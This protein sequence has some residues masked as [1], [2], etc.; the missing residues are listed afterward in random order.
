MTEGH[1]VYLGIVKWCKNLKKMWHD[2]ES[3]AT[4]RGICMKECGQL[5]T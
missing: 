4:S 5:A 2:E 3:V 1:K